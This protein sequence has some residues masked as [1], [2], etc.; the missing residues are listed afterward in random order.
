MNPQ[1]VDS[2]K[3][4]EGFR[5]KAYLDSAGVWTI[6]FGTN[7]QVLSISQDMAEEF[8]ASAIIKVEQAL[9]KTQTFNSLDEVRQ[10]VLI[11]MGYQLG[12]TGCL[13]FKK[14]WA[15]LENM[16][17]WAA[18]SEMLDSAWAKIQTPKRAETLAARMRD[19]TWTG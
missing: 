17:Y 2:I 7:L 4:H 6:G 14:M 5:S 12:I 16:D 10:S 3:Q 1:L 19:G 15:A 13:N 18:A 9:S 11:E 8:L